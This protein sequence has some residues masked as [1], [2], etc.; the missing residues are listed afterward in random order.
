MY[1]HA[2]ETIGRTGKTVSA[3]DSGTTRPENAVQYA[4]SATGGRFVARW[5]V[6]PV[7]R[8][9]N[10]ASEQSIC[11]TVFAEGAAEKARPLSCPLC[12]P[13]LHFSATPFT[14]KLDE[15]R[16]N[17]NEGGRKW[18]VSRCRRCIVDEYLSPSTLAVCIFHRRNSINAVPIT[19]DILHR[20]EAACC[21]SSTLKIEFSFNG[22]RLSLWKEDCLP[23]YWQARDDR[24]KIRFSAIQ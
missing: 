4:R 15:R 19:F 10:T 12:L 5:N 2:P 24:R 7:D 11:L 8:P 9:G 22:E 13:C 21:S 20:E 17:V 6:F 14:T 18:L 1:I 16:K 3:I 23:T